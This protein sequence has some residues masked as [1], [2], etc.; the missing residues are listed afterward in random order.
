VKNGDSIRIVVDTNV[1]I[2]FLIG[3]VLAGLSESIVNDKVQILFSE[4]LFDELVTVLRRPKFER[5]FSQDDVA[6]LVSLLRLKAEFVD[7]VLNFNECR[8]PKDNFL[9][10]LGVS[11]NADYLI[12][13]DEDL[14]SLNPFHGVRI[15]NFRMFQDI[16]KIE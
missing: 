3:K 5:Y 6:E 2:G 15:V 11:G 14:L 9:L 7:I 10:D 4:E 16:L 13:G 12:T 8:D 1:W